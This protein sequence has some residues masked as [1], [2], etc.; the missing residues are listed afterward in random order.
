MYYKMKNKNP[1]RDF[2]YHSLRIHR[3]SL[4]DVDKGKEY[5]KL[6]KIMKNRLLENEQYLNSSPAFSKR[7]AHWNQ[8]NIDSIQPVK[9][10]KNP[11][12]QFK[13]EF[14]SA[15]NGSIE[16]VATFVSISLGW[17]TSDRYRE[18]WIN[19]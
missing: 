14:E 13:R 17:F 8:R 1:F 4:S 11:W 10:S 3:S 9:N 2:I 12:I 6:Y 15:T 19:D 5:L 7:C 16:E 18:D